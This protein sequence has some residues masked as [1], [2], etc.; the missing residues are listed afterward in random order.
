MFNNSFGTISLTVSHCTNTYT[1][2]RTFCDFKLFLS[3]VKECLIHDI[4]I[5]V[6]AFADYQILLD[7]VSAALNRVKSTLCAFI[8]WWLRLDCSAL[9]DYSILNF[10]TS[11]C[12]ISLL[13]YTHQQ[14][15]EISLKKGDPVCV[16]SDNDADQNGHSKKAH[17][18][19]VR[20]EKGCGFVP[21]F[22]LKRIQQF[23]GDSSILIGST[24]CGIVPDK[25][26][27]KFPFSLPKVIFN[28]IFHR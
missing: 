17:W 20:C 18:A 7:K 23:E 11:G 8:P 4:D 25:K 10:V 1:I 12:A 21:S 13:T 16:I 26:L 9:D 24:A 3:K 19:F 2:V 14:A 28:Y 6:S 5:S 15:N 22:V 27:L